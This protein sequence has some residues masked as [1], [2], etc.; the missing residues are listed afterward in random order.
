[1]I[2]LSKTAIHS[3]VTDGLKMRT[4]CA[5][6]LSKILIPDPRDFH[7]TISEEIDRV[8]SYLRFKKHVITGDESWMFLYDLET[9]RQREEWHTQ[10][11]LEQIRLG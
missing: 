9:K 7:V 1:M 5:K 10:T 4:L 6:M 11:Q 8:T 2:G 3:I